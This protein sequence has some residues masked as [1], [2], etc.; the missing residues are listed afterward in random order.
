MSWKDDQKWELDW[1]GNCANSFWEETKQIVYARKMGLSATMIE[2]KYPSYDLQ[3]KSV[4]DIGGGAYSMLLKCVNFNKAIVVDPC[5]Y[6]Q[7]TVDRYKETKIQV[8]K[9]TG[10]D[11][12][13]EEIHDE[14]W[15]YNCLQH[16]IDPEQIIKNMQSYSRIIRVFEWVDNGISIGHPHDLKEGLLNEWFGGEGKVEQINESGCH[17]KVYYGVFK[18]DHYEKNK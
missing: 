13:T 4:I 11:Y 7:W 16:T 6:P 15:L 10:E 12:K 14:A 8:I 9:N 17:G 2:G 18:G 5:D 1:H 3:N